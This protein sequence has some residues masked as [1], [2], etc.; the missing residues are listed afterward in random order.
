MD[1]GTEPGKVSLPDR[2]KA[3]ILAPK[4]EWPKIAA[5]ATT[6]GQ[7]LKRY[8]L[9]L[10]AIGPVADFLGGQIFGYGL[11][12]ISWTPSPLPALLQA[13]VYYLLIIAGVFVLS[14]IAD[15]LAPKFEGQ[16]NRTNAVK[17]VA[18][19]AT[20]A[21]LAGIF[22][23]VPSLA[24][25]KLLGLYSLFLFYTG[26]VPLMK[27]PEERALGYTAVTFLC[28]IALFIVVGLIA[29]RIASPPTTVIVNNPGELSG[30]EPNDVFIRPFSGNPSG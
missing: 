19:G 15:F 16:S 3:L 11:L 25:F 13:V 17:L 23:L 9:P 14:L 26:A 22:G 12:G 7:I 5:E 10:A 24:V 4:E 29:G 1:D 20:A 2:V 27:V 30:M 28:G 18:Y 21:W 6:Q 8:V